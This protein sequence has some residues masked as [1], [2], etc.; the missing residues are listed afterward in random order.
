MSRRKT[1][2]RTTNAEE[3]LTEART[4]ARKDRKPR[5][6]DAAAGLLPTL[7]QWRE[8]RGQMDGRELL[9]LAKSAARLELRGAM[10]SADDRADVQAAIV[11]RVLGLT[12]GALP[13]HDSARVKLGRLCGDAKDFRDA[14]DSRRERDRIDSETRSLELAESA[15]GLGIDSTPADHV[16]IVARSS[17]RAASL[18]A[19]AI[20]AELGLPAETDSAAWR[21]LYQW[22]RAETGEV[23]AAELGVTWGAWKV[24]AGRGAKFLRGFYSAAA[25]LD[26]LTLGARIGADGIIYSLRDDSREAHSRTRLLADVS[27]APHWREGTDAGT[28]PERPLDRASAR[29]ACVVTR[30]KVRRKRDRERAKGDVRAATAAALGKLAREHAAGARR[31]KSTARHS[32]LAPLA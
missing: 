8:E 13:R 28:R 16:A 22:A 3:R 24:S 23:C 5:Q 27:T 21:V 10:Y 7:A 6:L 2:I 12:C 17:V 14:I 30:C 15:A 25:L 26:R 9:K 11:A 31:E 29:A 1:A 20:A 19:D 4:D 32:A 18:A